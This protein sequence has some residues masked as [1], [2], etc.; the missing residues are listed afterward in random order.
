MDHFF[1][2]PAFSLASKQFKLIADY[3]NISPSMRE[4]LF[5]PKR[6]IAVSLPVKMD[7]GSIENFEGYRVQHHLAMGPTKGGIRFTPTLTMGEVAA[8]A[9]W[10]SWKCALTGLPYGGATGGVRVDPRQLSV[11]E[12][13]RLSRRFMQEMIPFVGPRSDIMGPDMG[14]DERVMAWLMDTYSAYLGYSEPGIVTGKPVS[15]GGTIGRREATGLGVVYL[16]ER[17]ADMIKLKLAGGSAVVQGFGNVGSVVAHGLAYRNGMKIIGLGDTSGSYFD[18]SGIDIWRAQS[19]ILENGD[20]R[21]FEGAER[22]SANDLLTLP[23]DVLV[24]AAV[25]GVINGQNAAKLR[26]RILAEAANGPTTTEADKVLFE[27][28]NEIFMI[29]DILCNAGGVVVSYFEWVQGLQSFF[30]TRSEI[31]DRLFRTM[32]QAFVAVTR[33]AKQQKIPHRV[34]ALAIAV[35]RVMKARQEFG[36]FP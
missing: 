30:W 31:V 26:C 3:L 34:S 1:D 22:I 14:T 8:L 33:R 35:E 9:I 21:N 23:C 24:P 15:I 18:K 5:W 7:D 20:L 13:E 25:S 16:I 6:C 29:P 36:L 2:A 27:R 28:W 11:A 4:P 19:Y 12:L 17:A 10:M 32:E